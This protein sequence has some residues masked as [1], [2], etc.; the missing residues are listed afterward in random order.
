MT[1]T[2]KTKVQQ[3]SASSSSG[4][5][6]DES[7]R[8]SSDNAKYI[9]AAIVFGAAIGNIFVAKSKMRSFKFSIFKKSTKTNT[10]KSDKSRVN[11]PHYENFKNWDGRTNT[12]GKSYF[13]EYVDPHN[14]M[15]ML[16]LK[17]LNALNLPISKMPTHHEVKEAYRVIA[18]AHHPDRNINSATEKSV[19]IF[20]K[21][22][23][24]KNKL[25]QT[26]A[27]SK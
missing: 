22:S 18:L 20:N 4:S 8:T 9:I 6:T 5:K 1:S 14:K 21:A 13:D 10:D 7:L 26:L 11:E 17:Y 2:I 19:D 25:L 3:L 23:D 15:L 16:S 27:Y 12:A 24:A